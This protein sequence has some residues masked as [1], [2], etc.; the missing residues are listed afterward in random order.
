MVDPSASPDAQSAGM[1]DA[2]LLRVLME[3]LPDRV[4]FKNLESQF[5]RVNRAHARWLGVRAPEEVVGKT[6]ADF[7]SAAHAQA[8]LANE[9]EIIRSGQSVVGK[10]ERITKHDGTEAWGSTTKLPWRDA[11]G[12][13]IGTFGIT[14]DITAT[15]AAE[16]KLLQERNLLRT[17]IDHL[18]SRI[19]VKDNESR[20][21]LNNRAHQASL[22]VA[23]QEDALGRTVLDFHPNERGRQATE[24]DRGVLAGGPPII[25]QERSDFGSGEAARW[26][27]TTKVP[28]RDLRGAIVGLVG[29]SHDITERKRTEQE[30][31]LRNDE[32]EAD[33]R[34][35]RQIQE[36]F[37]PHSFPAFPRGVPAEASGLRFAHRYVP[38][39]TLGGDFFNV[40][41]LSDTQA[42]VLVC[43]VMGHGVRAGLLTALIR[44]VVEEMGERAQSPAA[45]LAEIN[46]GLAP[47][48]RGTGQPVF[49]TVFYGV[50]DLVSATLTHA[51]AGHPP[52]FLV[53][54]ETGAVEQLT[55]ASP[56]PAT[57][58][59]EAFVYTERVCRF[60]SG[61][62]LLA[63]TDG[64]FEATDREG[65]I[66]GNDRLRELIRENAAQ[67]PARL[68]ER[69]VAG[70]QSFTGRAE[71]DDDICV[72]AAE[73][74]GISCTVAPAV[75]EV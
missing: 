50:I 12:R 58:L 11:T 59:M 36:V 51:N 55:E 45:V 61:D 20:F 57:G 53:R 44:G 21:L 2:E 15:R 41:Q 7:F 27:L 63:Y 62:V 3:T 72:L 49:A 37:L 4:Y 47:I 1:L 13:I 42:A 46:R 5:V 14:R 28:F 24:D 34:M 75:W 31:R 29:I 16:E 8:A 54:H 68:V 71:F 66:F 10:V 48:L 60:G 65:T 52:A 64:L 9:Q 67:P 26:A 25:N 6:D 56:E 18:P 73:S 40:L 69:L 22:G 23:S 17:I 19:F 43:D 38:A 30:L 39:A 32:V 35:A 33:V 74:T 70:V